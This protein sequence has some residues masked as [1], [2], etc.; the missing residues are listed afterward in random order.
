MR[1]RHAT[2][3]W[4]GL[5]AAS[6]SAP[7]KANLTLSFDQSDYS[8]ASVGGTVDVNVLL[9]QNATGEQATAVYIAGIK[10][11]IDDPSIAQVLSGAD[12]TPGT[13]FSPSSSIVSSSE[14]RLGEASADVLS[15]VPIGS[16]GS[17]LLGTLRF[18]GL[19]PGSTLTL[20]TQLD[21]TTP[22]FLTD[23]PLVT[24]PSN[25][26]SATITVGGVAPVPEPSTLVSAIMAGLTG[27]GVAWRRRFASRA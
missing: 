27:V 13:G 2:F 4:L 9:N 20:V 3:V 22:D 6:W 1:L 10:L 11:T 18:T 24:D 19:A 14:V 8:I 7:A 5:L 15:G 21:A 16:P 26:A 23:N 12:V 17:I 25:V